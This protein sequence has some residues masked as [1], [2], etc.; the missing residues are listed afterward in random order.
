MK[1]LAK[2]ILILLAAQIVVIAQEEKPESEQPVQEVFQTELVYPQEKGEVQITFGTTFSRN[3]ASRMFRSP[4]SLEY[5]LTNRWQVELEWNASTY[6]RELDENETSRGTGD[7]RF[8]TKYSFMNIANSPY[9]AAFGFEVGLPTASIHK[10]LTEGFIEY[11]PYVAVARD[12]KK[13]N[14]A[15]IFAQLGFGFMQRFKSVEHDDDEE[16][17]AGAHELSVNV[18]AFVP[19]RKVRFT[20]EVNWQNNRW[21][22]NGDENDLYVTPGFIYQPAHHWEVGFGVPVGTTKSADNFRA[23]FKLVREF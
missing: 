17:E 1:S 18:G 4:I 6:K 5:G 2:F 8:G 20:A 19:F 7:L 16:V 21:N 22:N 9:H 3:S 23:I 15:Q 10:G 14:R 11:E 13:L 12:F